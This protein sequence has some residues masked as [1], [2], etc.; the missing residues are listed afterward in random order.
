MRKEI[1]AVVFFLCLKSAASF[2]N[3]NANSSPAQQTLSGDVE[4]LDLNGD[5]YYDVLALHADLPVHGAGDYSAMAQLVSPS[6]DVVGGYRLCGYGRPAGM[7]GQISFIPRVDGLADSTGACHVNLWFDGEDVRNCPGPM[8]AMLT[9]FPVD[10]AGALLGTVGEFLIPLQITQGREHFGWQAI[11]ILGIDWQP[12]V[13]QTDTLPVRVGVARSGKFFVQ[14]WV[15]EGKEE[16]SFQAFPESLALGES[17]VHIPWKAGLRAD[18][19]EITFSTPWQPPWGE[20]H[21]VWVL[22]EDT[23]Q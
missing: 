4:P 16:I 20:T 1:G 6:P 23:G 2:N 22:P 3:A 15:Y 5:H 14:I 13:S 18:R 21:E 9:V 19:L 7:V 12:G 8:V 10:T 11:H 17:E